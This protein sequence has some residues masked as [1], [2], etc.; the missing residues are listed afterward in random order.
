LL[1]QASGVGQ[2]TL[3]PVLES[4]EARLL[5]AVSPAVS[6]PVAV[7]VYHDGPAS[8]VQQ[9]YQALRRF[10]HAFQSGSEG[11]DGEFGV[12]RPCSHDPKRGVLL[13]QW[14]EAQTLHDYLWRH[15]YHRNRQQSAMTRAFRWL[16]QFHQRGGTTCRV[17]DAGVYLNSLQFNLEQQRSTL[18]ARRYAELSPYLRQFSRLTSRFSALRVAH[19]DVHGDFA[20]RNL[21]LNPSQVFGIDIRASQN[22]PV[23]DDFARMLHAIAVGYPNMLTRADMKHPPQHWPLLRLLLEAYGYPDTEEQR[24]YLL[25]VLLYRLLFHRI[26]GRI[27]EDPGG[28]WGRWISYNTRMVLEGV[29]HHLSSHRG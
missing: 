17:A 27:A 23:A 28:L 6:V 26:K 25:L 29:S 11:A 15:F 13:M 12:P 3:E 18:S 1:E 20:P 5:R 16:Q 19:A 22:R 14:L 4:R 24:D 9:E 8:S 7:K 21:L 2:W 10:F